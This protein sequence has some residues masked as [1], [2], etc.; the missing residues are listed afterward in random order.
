MLQIYKNSKLEEYG[1]AIID[2]ADT[3]E[4]NIN[5]KIYLGYNLRKNS[6]AETY[7]KLHDRAKM[8]VNGEFKAFYQSSIEVFQ[9]GLL[10]LGNSYINS[11]CII[12]CGKHITI[13]DGCAIA[14]NVAIYDSDFH[15]IQDQYGT[16]QNPASSIRIGNHVWIGV[17][18]ILLKG[19]TV[20]D[21]AVIGAGTVVTRDVPEN[22]MVV[23]APAKVIKENVRWR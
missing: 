21:G 2:I 18:A 5:G 11:G 8:Y 19:I 4:L 1:K 3:A 13:G 22:S 23:G 7:L 14:R 6:M 17:G 9:D 15:M 16:C 10:E 12:S 20:G